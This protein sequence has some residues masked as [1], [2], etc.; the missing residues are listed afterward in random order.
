VVVTPDGGAPVQMGRGIWSRSPKACPARGTS[1]RTS[2]NIHVRVDG[3]GHEKRW[4]ASLARCGITACI[5]LVLLVAP[6]V[7]WL[8]NLPGDIHYRGRN[9]SFHFPVVTCLVVSLVLTV[10]LNLLLRWFKR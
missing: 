7:P 4:N 8:G 2:E 6:K 1:A 5:G 10:I 9:T 3:R